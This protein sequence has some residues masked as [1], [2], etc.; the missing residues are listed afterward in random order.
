MKKSIFKFIAPILSIL[1]FAGLAGGCG[2]KK[3]TVKITLSE[4]T[5]SVFYAP[6][7]VAINNGFFAEEGIEIELINGQGADKVMTAVISGSVDIGFAGPEAAIYVY[8]EGKEDYAEVFAQLTQKDG[9]FLVGRYP[10]DEFDWSDL[11]G[12]LVLP[13]RKGGVPY[14]TLEYVLKSKGLIPGENLTFDDSIQF[15][16]MAG[17][18]ASGHG[19]YVTIFEPTASML[20]AE[21]KGYILASIGMESGEIPYTAYFAKKSFIGKNPELIQRFTN[22][23]YKAQLWVEEHSPREIAEALAPSF[24]DTDIELLETVVTRYKDIDAYSKTP[25]MKEEAFEKLQTV[26]S[27]AGELKEKAPFSELINNSFAE[28]AVESIS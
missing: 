5:H 8:N 7:Y 23:L 12:S 10:A 19:D 20:E 15:A 28:K 18:F 9:S 22:A 6:Q 24:P 2:G 4:V 27:Q 21:G 16:Q 13:G 14:M 1:V 11:E 17:S 3:D 26:M 25:V